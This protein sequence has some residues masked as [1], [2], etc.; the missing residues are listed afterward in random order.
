MR[1]LLE[2]AL[3]RFAAALW[4]LALRIGRRQGGA[5]ERFE[6]SARRVLADAADREIVR[7]RHD[8]PDPPEGYVLMAPR[9]QL[10]ATFASSLLLVDEAGRR[11]VPIFVGPT[12][13]LAFQHRLEQRR[14]A[15]PLP[16]DLFEALVREVGAFVGSARIDSIESDVFIAA[17][18]LVF[19]DDRSLEL[20]ARASDAI[21]VAMGTGAPI[22]VAEDVLARAGRPLEMLEG[23]PET[24]GAS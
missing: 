12:E 2:L 16:Y 17:L 7:S 19:E 18:V 14:P 22:V 15:R 4:S 1:S 23:D 6:A 8:H 10:A 24:A 21:L 20:D 3:V 5:R 9:A 13:A 11:F